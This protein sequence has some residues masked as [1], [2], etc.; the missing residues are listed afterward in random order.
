M[1]WYGM[2]WYGMVWYGMVWYGM[3]WYGTVWY[4]MVWY[5]MVFIYSKFHFL[6]NFFRM[7]KVCVTLPLYDIFPYIVRSMKIV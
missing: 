7:K 1:V 4:G 5:G 3:V 2:V 6:I